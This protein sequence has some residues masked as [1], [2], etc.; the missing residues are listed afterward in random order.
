MPIILTISGYSQYYIKDKI[1]YRKS[2][3]V[4]SNKIIQYRAERKINRSIKNNLEG[5]YLILNNKQKF[6][7]LKKLKHRLKKV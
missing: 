1:L 2:Y 7:P 4:K 6:V 5:Y 3:I